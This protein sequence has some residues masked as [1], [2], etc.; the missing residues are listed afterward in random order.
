VS[1]IRLRPVE[2]AD[3]PI[4]FEHQRDPESSAMAGVPARERAAF[5]EQWER[6]RGDEVSFVRTIV[7]DGEVVGNLMSWKADGVREI[8]YRIGREHWGQGVASAALAAFVREL[9]ERP[10]HASVLPDNHASRRVLEKVGMERHGERG[11]R[12]LWSSRTNRVPAELL[13]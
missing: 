11:S 4:F 12:V 3:L 8:G 1:D 6:I 10:L 7:G 9:D 5:D 2:D 13:P